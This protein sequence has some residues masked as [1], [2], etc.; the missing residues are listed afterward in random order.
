MHYLLFTS[1]QIF[2]T[3]SSFSSLANVL[4]SPQ[5]FSSFTRS[6]SMSPTPFAVG[7]HTV[8][9]QRWSV[10]RRGRVML[11]ENKQIKQKDSYKLEQPQTKVIQAIKYWPTVTK[12]QVAST[13]HQTKRHLPSLVRIPVG[14]TACT[15]LS[16][17][18]TIIRPPF[19]AMSTIFS[20]P[21]DSSSYHNRNSPPKVGSQVGWFKY[22]KA[23]NFLVSLF[24]SIKH[25]DN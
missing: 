18:N 5:C 13:L 25:K 24:C 15:K 17:K 19:G 2:T 7:N 10:D 8:N 12:E 16:E 21:V 9:A 3:S 20:S 23:V 14:I 6:S 1:Y 4:P 11:K 22:N